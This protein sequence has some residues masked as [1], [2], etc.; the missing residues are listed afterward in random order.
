MVKVAR[1]WLTLRRAVIKPN[2]FAMGPWAFTSSPPALDSMLS[3]WPPRWVIRL[4]TSPTNSL[5]V[6]RSTAI[7]GSSSTG[8]A[9]RQ[10]SSKPRL[11]QASK[12]NSVA[13]SSEYPAPVTVT[14]M[15]MQGY[16]RAMPDW[17]AA[18]MPRSTA[19][20][21]SSGTAGLFTAQAYLL[22]V[23]RSSGS[24]RRVNEAAFSFPAMTLE[25]VSV[26]SAGT[27]MDSR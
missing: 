18:V 27:L 21:M 24:R 13:V 2:I 7:M 19:S 9:V 11:A 5:G 10:A 23:P 8:D 1:P 15:S 14:P 20:R 6:T 3:T 12:A 16:P 22:P 25:K 26:L 4:I 17:K